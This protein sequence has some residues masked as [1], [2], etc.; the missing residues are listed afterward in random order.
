[1]MSTSPAKTKKTTASTHW[2]AVVGTVHGADCIR[3]LKK[4]RLRQG[5][6]ML[7]FRAD[8]LPGDDRRLADLL[9]H[10]PLPAILTVRDPAEGGT[11]RAGLEERARRYERLGPD[12]DALDIELRNARAMQSRITAAK[13]SGAAVILSFH[14]FEGTPGL[15]TL[16]QRH[17]AATKYG[18][19][20]FKVAATPRNAREL[21]R[22]LEFT[23]QSPLP[24]SVMAMG[25]WGMAA[26][27][28]LAQAGSALQYGYLH[29]PNAEGQWQAAE[30]AALVAK[31]PNTTGTPPGGSRQS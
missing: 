10:S 11:G 5:V 27:L 26:R 16:R 12:A 6:G 8:S 30:L 13:A 4:T 25:P 19:D 3:A 24:V 28:L 22:L 17:D 21:A 2:P 23:L 15:S 29:Q 7:E 14:D 18:A 1:M 9:R 20:V 31:L